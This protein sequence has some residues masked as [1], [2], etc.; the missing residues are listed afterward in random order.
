MIRERYWE[1][2][3]EDMTQEEREQIFIDGIIDSQIMCEL[4]NEDLESED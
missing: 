1:L 2:D 3:Y 4:F